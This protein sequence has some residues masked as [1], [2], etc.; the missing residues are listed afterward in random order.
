V[1]LCSSLTLSVSL[2]LCLSVSLSLCLSV[3]LSLCL[4]ASLPLSVSLSLCLSVSLPLCLSASL[5]LCLAVSLSLSDHC[6][7]LRVI[8]CVR[9]R[10]PPFSKTATRTA[11]NN[12]SADMACDFYIKLVLALLRDAVRARPFFAPPAHRAVCSPPAPCLVHL[13]DVLPCRLLCAGGWGQGDFTVSVRD[14]LGLGI[15]GIGTGP[16]LVSAATVT[17]VMTALLPA[18][19]VKLVAGR[20][21][22]V[23]AD[24]DNFWPLDGALEVAHEP[25][26][27]LHAQR[28]Q[29]AAHAGSLPRSALLPYRCSASHRSA[30]L[31]YRCSASHRLP[32]ALCVFFAGAVVPVVRGPPVHRASHL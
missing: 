28:G 23:L 1:V 22:A 32:P 15:E 9:A 6:A 25:R 14:F 11:L 4:S 13:P 30:L 20:M 19:V 10:A 18:D 2:S 12:L 8:W 26:T 31:P 24:S 7:L 16:L 29:H 17:R 21:D 3:S 27:A 5:S